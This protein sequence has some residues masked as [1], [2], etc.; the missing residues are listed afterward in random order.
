MCTHRSPAYTAVPWNCS[1]HADACSCAPSTC[2]RL[3]E[4]ERA[5]DRSLMLPLFTQLSDA[6][7][8]R[9]VAALADACSLSMTGR[10]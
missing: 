3:V 5:E 2:E 8:D 9:V 6:D 1:G 4:S 10:R 7:Q